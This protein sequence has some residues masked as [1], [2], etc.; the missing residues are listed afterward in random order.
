MSD[1]PTHIECGNPIFRVEDMAG[2]VR[3]YVDVLGFQNAE[4]GDDDFT[5]V[6]RDGAGI[7]LCRGGQGRGGA[8]AWIGVGDVRALHELYRQR[9]AKIVLEPTNFPWALE[10]QLEDPAGNVLRFGSE[11]E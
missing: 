6:A 7:Y 9:G 11:P 5:C 2:A 10:M 1:L 8:W 4:W 3:F